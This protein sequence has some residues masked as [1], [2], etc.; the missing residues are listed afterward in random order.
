MILNLVTGR[1][2]VTLTV[3]IEFATF[4]YFGSTQSK[5]KICVVPVTLHIFIA[6]E[7]IFQ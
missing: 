6:I 2:I 4:K 7:M 3:L 5:E 1:E